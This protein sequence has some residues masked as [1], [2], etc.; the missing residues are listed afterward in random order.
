MKR[1]SKA[2]MQRLFKS[3]FFHEVEAIVKAWDYYLAR[4]DSKNADEMAHKWTIAKLALE[5]ITGKG[6]RFF[7]DGIDS[8]GVVN[9]RDSND[10]IIYGRNDF[11]YKEDLP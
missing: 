8:Y 2:S 6:Y 1:M 10:R 7:R 5:H 11:E 4:G 3:K 9:E